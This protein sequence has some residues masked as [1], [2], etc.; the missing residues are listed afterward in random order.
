MSSN[1]RVPA[2][3]TT[4]GGEGAG[5]QDFTAGGTGCGAGFALFTTCTEPRYWCMPT[6][7][8]ETAINWNKAE[9]TDVK[10]GTRGDFAAGAAALALEEILTPCD[11]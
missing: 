9:R 5:A 1:P 6:E 11:S 4:A 10:R 2:W 3:E 8:C 7:N